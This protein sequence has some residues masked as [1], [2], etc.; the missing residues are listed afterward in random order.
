MEAI[1]RNSNTA[2]RDG[3]GFEIGWRFGRAVMLGEGR[4][5]IDYTPTQDDMNATDWNIHTPR[6]E[7][8]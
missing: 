1:R 5:H 6:Q 2:T 3:A 7:R 8:T 4:Q